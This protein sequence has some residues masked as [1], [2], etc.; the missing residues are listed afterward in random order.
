MEDILPG[1]RARVGAR[2][3]SGARVRARVRVS[4]RAEDRGLR[5]EG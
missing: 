4:V 1:M 3:R 5:A 2:V